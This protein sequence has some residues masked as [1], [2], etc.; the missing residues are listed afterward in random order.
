MDGVGEFF[1]VVRRH[2]QKYEFLQFCNGRGECGQVVVA[3]VYG[4]QILQS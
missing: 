1:N 2:V 3:D 4:F